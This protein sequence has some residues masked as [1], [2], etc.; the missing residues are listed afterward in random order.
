[1][2]ATRSLALC[3]SWVASLQN[4]PAPWDR[5]PHFLRWKVTFTCVLPARFLLRAP[6]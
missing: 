6:G 2:V 1:M 3:H 5:V 4:P